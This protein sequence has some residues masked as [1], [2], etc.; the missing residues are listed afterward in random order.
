VLVSGSTAF[1]R[2][3]LILVL[4]LLHAPSVSAEGEEQSSER[5]PAIWMVEYENDL[6]A[7]EDRFY[8][9]GM[10]LSRIAEAREAPSWLESVAERFPG[11]SDYD[12]LPYRLSVGH[13][14]YTPADIEHPEFPPDDRPYAAWLYTQ[15][16]TGTLHHHGADRVRVG[17]GVVGPLALGRQIQ[18]YAHELIDSPE[19]RGW[20]T[21]IR[22]EPTLQIGYDRMRRFL[23]RAQPEQLGFDLS[24]LAGI[25]AGNAHSHATLGGFARVG[26]NLPDDYGPPRISP[27]ASGS[28]YFRAEGPQQSSF[29]FFIGAEGR[30]V[31]RD[32]FL[33]GNT[34]GGVSGVPMERQVGE[35]FAGAVL[36]RGVFR[37]AYS[38]V[39]RTREFVGQAGDQSYGA[40]SFSIWW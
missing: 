4:V 33:Q 22:N 6:F 7:G 35:Y 19:P 11:F 14:I 28:S 23:D 17:L 40:L 39:W 30:H 16:S 34:F 5:T 29:Y 20:D 3:P 9:S 25:T 12:A 31:F 21:Q 27:A 2:F 26:Y 38:H 24:W 15:F 8:T 36:T 32:M 10:R 13:N 18:K 37:L 1:S